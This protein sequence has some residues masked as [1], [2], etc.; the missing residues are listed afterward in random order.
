MFTPEH[1]LVSKYGPIH[2]KT[3]F[4]SEYLMIE[5]FEDNS[6]DTTE[7]D[8]KLS[9]AQD[10]CVLPVFSLDVRPKRVLRRKNPPVFDASQKRF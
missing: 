10:I 4:S 5:V 7:D 6:Q 9:K 1:K 2:R 8:K 3:V